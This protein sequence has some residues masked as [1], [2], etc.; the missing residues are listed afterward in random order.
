MFSPPEMRNMTEVIENLYA[1]RG[2]NLKR[3]LLKLGAEHSVTSKLLDKKE[4]IALAISLIT[5]EE[6]T[7]SNAYKVKVAYYV[8]IFLG[9]VLF[10]FVIKDFLIAFV[11]GVTSFFAAELFLFKTKCRTMKMA[12][13]HGKIIGKGISVF[14]C[15]FMLVLMSSCLLGLDK[16]LLGLLLSLA[17]DLLVN[18]IQ[19]SIV[20]SWVI[21]RSSFLRRYLISTFSLPMSPQQMLGFGSSS[22]ALDVGPMI[23]LW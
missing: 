21:P 2:K 7:K 3:L 13:K 1:M 23:T 20:G 18:A 9:L 4:L 6:A 15:E 12:V 17:C 19:L 22:F 10:I 16:G 5:E 8:T 14:I 11:E